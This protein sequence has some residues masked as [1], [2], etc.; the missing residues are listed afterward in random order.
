MNLAIFTAKKSIEHNRHGAVIA[1]RGSILNSGW[2]KD[3]THPAAIRYYSK[4]IHAELAAVIGINKSD[5]INADVYVARVMRTKH[6]P[7]GMSRPCKICMK[8]L[9]EA[10]IRHAYYTNK[11]GDWIKETL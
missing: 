9:Q 3:K 1:Q 11:D 5:L 2:N 10:G 4:C 6:E 8:M 7:L